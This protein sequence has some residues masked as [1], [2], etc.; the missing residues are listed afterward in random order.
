MWARAIGAPH[1]WQSPVVAVPKPTPLSG[2][3]TRRRRTCSAALGSLYETGS[4]DSQCIEHESV[5][6][7]GFVEATRSRFGVGKAHSVYQWRLLPS[8]GLQCAEEIAS[9]MRPA[10]ASAYSPDCHILIDIG[11]FRDS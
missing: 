5:I 6:S 4:S 9:G 2:Q 7:T 3:R 8:I 1:R 10:E 11:S